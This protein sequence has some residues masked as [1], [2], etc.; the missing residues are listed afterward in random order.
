MSGIRIVNERNPERKRAGS[1]AAANMLLWAGLLIM[2]WGPLVNFSVG[3]IGV[4]TALCL[5]ARQQ[6]KKAEKKICPGCGDAIE[7][8]STTCPACMRDVP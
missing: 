6:R 5:L 2:I 3:A 7:W 4:G 8:E 1:F